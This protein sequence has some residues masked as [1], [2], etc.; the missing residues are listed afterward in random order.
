LEGRD[1]RAQNETGDAGGNAPAVSPASD[2]WAPYYAAAAKD[3]A[4]REAH[5]QR[6]VAA[7]RT[8]MRVLVFVAT[9]IALIGYKACAD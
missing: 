1:R 2:T 4:D 8:A 6:Q 9:A 3:A 5:R 7:A